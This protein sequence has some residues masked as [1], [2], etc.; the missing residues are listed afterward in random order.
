[1]S[2][3]SLQSRNIKPAKITKVS[4]QSIAE[5]LGLTVGDA[6]VSINGEQPRDL[7]DYN[8]LCAEEYLR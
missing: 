7:I 5:E 3:A 8:F 1:M 4:P 6:I 2:S